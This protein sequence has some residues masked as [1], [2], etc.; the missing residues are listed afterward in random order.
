MKTRRFALLMVGVLV[1]LAILSSGC[2]LEPAPAKASALKPD[3]VVERFYR[4][5]LDYPGNVL[6]DEAYRT[7]EY[8][9]EELVQRVDDYLAAQSGGPGG[10]DPFLCAQDIPGAIEVDEAVISGE[11]AEVVVHKVWNAGTE[12]ESVYD[13]TVL[14][15]LV[16]GDWLID[17]VRCAPPAASAS[18]EEVVEGFY[19]SYIGYAMTQGNPLVDRFYRDSDYLSPAFVAKVDGIL[20]GGARYDP[21]LC[22]QDVPAAY[23]VDPAEVQGEE[24]EVRFHGTWNAGTEYESSNEV[25]VLLRLIEGAWKID[26]IICE[27]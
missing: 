2:G 1:G 4:W 13:H 23:T 27:Q 14:L 5:Y 22:A 3:V 10:G 15:R 18:P 24:A 20:D 25:I 12:Y 19:G 17:E 21:I 6:V 9:T 7:S 26:G 8:L 11:S 16:D